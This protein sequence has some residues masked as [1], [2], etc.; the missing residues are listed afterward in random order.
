MAERRLFVPARVRIAAWVM[1]LAAVVLFSVTLV[2]RDLLLRRVDGAVAAAL[3]REA[4]EFAGVASA[5]TEPGTQ[6]AFGG[7]REVLY[8]HLRRE[9]P[10]QDEV[11]A[12][13]VD[14]GEIL[15]QQRVEK[16]PLAARRDVLDPI[17]ASAA[18]SGSARTEAGELRWV[19][20]AVVGPSGDRGALVIGYLVDGRRAEVDA[21][22]GTLVPVGLAGLALAGGIAWLVAGQILAPVRMVSRAAGQIS[23]QDLT[24]RIPVRGRDDIAALAVRFNAML[25]RLQHAFIT[26]RQF[27][28]DASHELR[29]PI[30]IIRGHLE[31]MGDDPAERAE[32]VRLC[33]DELDRMTR[34]VND[35]LVLATAERPD[36]VRREPVELAELT[37][38][39]DAKVRVLAQRRWRLES[40]AEGCARL[41]PQRITQAMVQLAQN[42]VQHSRD[43]DEIRLGSSLYGGLASFWVTDSGPGVAEQD[44]QRIFQRFTRG[45]GGGP[46]T[47]AGLGLAIVSAIADAHGGSVK[48]VSTPGRGATFGLELPVEV[49]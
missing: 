22:I 6:R 35:L 15:R 43:G 12:G 32:V 19:K 24:R 30:T 11:L 14:T 18:T 28:D 3:A 36:F 47:G 33:T 38:E 1:V 45:S 40:I 13:W 42:A 8:D 46:R 44:A 48:L 41:D 23:E 31:V 49:S 5:G 39:V 29:T 20:V 2:T 7:V 21:T 27:V 4:N 26:Q 34:F 9:Y 17:V 10:D 25:D 37:S 16:F